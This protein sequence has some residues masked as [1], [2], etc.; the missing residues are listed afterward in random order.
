MEKQLRL[1]VLPDSVKRYTGGSGK[2]QLSCDD[3]GDCTRTFALKMPLQQIQIEA[4]LSDISTRRTC[5]CNY[6][7][8]N[9]SFE[10]SILIP[11]I[12]II[13]YMTTN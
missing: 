11:F 7:F 8:C 13:I 5:C 12:A 1:S 10:F 3:T 6:D 9:A 4:C 2:T